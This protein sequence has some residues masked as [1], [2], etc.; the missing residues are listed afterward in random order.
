MSRVTIIGD[1]VTVVE[2]DTDDDRVLLDPAVLP[3]AL[4]WEL[5]PEGLCRADTCVPVRD[6]EAFTVGDRVDLAGVAAALGRTV[7]VDAAAG[8]AAV[9][10]PREERRRA[11]TDL[12]APP[13]TLTDLDGTHHSLDEW[14]GRKRLL[15]A[16]SSW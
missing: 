5:K 12:E 8:Y 14:R 4:G 7:V 3:Q 1:D 2:A 9:A 15:H 11:L 10:L 16:F 13:F 6:R